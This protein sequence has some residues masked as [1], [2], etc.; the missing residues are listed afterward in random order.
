MLFE[1]IVGNACAIDTLLWFYKDGRY[2]EASILNSIWKSPNPNGT[3]HF[4]KTF[5]INLW[6]PACIGLFI[7]LVPVVGKNNRK[8]GQQTDHFKIV[9]KQKF[10]LSL[11]SSGDNS[12]CTFSE[13]PYAFRQ[14]ACNAKLM[15]LLLPKL[16]LDPYLQWQLLLL[17]INFI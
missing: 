5:R 10:I 3:A 6:Y 15:W 2:K 14:G 13:Y 16:G 8:K 4:R 9:K 7:F 11:L 17:E 12:I 1:D